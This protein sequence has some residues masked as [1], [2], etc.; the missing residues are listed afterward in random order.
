MLATNAKVKLLAS[1][2]GGVFSVAF[3][4]LIKEVLISD[5]ATLTAAL[6]GGCIGLWLTSGS[7]WSKVVAKHIDGMNRGVWVLKAS[8][9]IGML[10]SMIVI[11]SA[12]LVQFVPNIPLLGSLSVNV[13][14]PALAGMMSLGSIVLFPLLWAPAMAAARRFLDSKW[15]A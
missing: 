1:V 9:S 10:L 7:I 4:W 11:G 15:R 8:A 2:D 6:F 14:E 5:E 13:P 12:W 3:A